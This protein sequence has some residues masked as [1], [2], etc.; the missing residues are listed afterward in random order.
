MKKTVLSARK[1]S[2]TFHSP[3]P[4]EVLKE[5]SL[6]LEAGR[7]LA[8]MGK[9]GE[10][11]STLLHILGTLEK[12]TSG[13][14]EIC[15]KSIRSSSLHQIRNQH[16]GFIFQSYNLLEDYS[17]LENV[18]MPAR[19]ARLPVAKGSRMHQR[20]LDLLESVGLT[21]RTHFLTKLL[22]GGEKQR[23]AICRALCT[24]PALILA[25]EPSGNLDH[26]QSQEIHDLLIRL[27]KEQGR[28]LI[29]ATHDRELA[30]LCDEQL[31]L[32]DG[33]LK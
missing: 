7:S 3:T 24:D 20:A 9:S 13:E 2:K 1:I 32:K 5:I 29:V 12:P 33:Y 4:V 26:A 27:T 28:A 10:G 14:I 15:G 11:K 6:E 22:S 25:D 16:I 17:V 18:L 30:A 23:V 8:I 31:H 19:I 21:P